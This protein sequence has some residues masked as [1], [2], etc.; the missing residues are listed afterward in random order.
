M[1]MQT[2]YFNEDWINH[3]SDM[4]SELVCQTGDQQLQVNLEAYMY[5]WLYRLYGNDPQKVVDT[6]PYMDQLMFYLKEYFNHFDT[7]NAE[8][9]ADLAIS[10]LEDV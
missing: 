4:Y 7:L 3:M 9:I 8:E 10:M 5:I 2:L 1:N 6:F